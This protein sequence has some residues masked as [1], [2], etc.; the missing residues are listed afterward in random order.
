MALYRLPDHCTPTPIYLKQLSSAFHSCIPTSL[1]FL[2]TSL[3]VLSIISWLFAQVPQIIKNY[4]IHSA[5]G[6]SI[7]FLAEWL[8]GDLTNLLGALLTGQAA[9]QVVVAFYYVTVDLVLCYQYLWYAHVKEWRKKRALG[10]HSD[11]GEEDDDAS[12]VL[13]GVAPSN[14]RSSTESSTASDSK[15]TVKTVKIPA[16]KPMT[17]SH[18]DLDSSPLQEKDT[19]TN[20]STIVRSTQSPFPAASPKATL[21]ISVLCVALSRASPLNA[22]AQEST[23][24]ESISEFVGR[25]LSWM[26]TLLYLGSRLP[27]IYKNAVR[28]S[29]SGL[30]PTLFI[31]AFCGNFFY[32]ASLLTNPLAWD[33]Y[34]PYG[35]HGWVGSEG[36]DRKTWIALA[37][38]FWLGAAGVL[39]MDATI[40]V[41]FLVYGED[42]EKSMVLVEDREGKSRWL[43]VKGWMRGW[44]PSPNKDGHQDGSDTTALLDG[45]DRRSRDYGTA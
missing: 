41:Q 1:A 4:Q 11:G 16:K 36:S 21:L 45:E 37:A 9:W 17:R 43:A 34:P 40:G 26:S 15:D 23:A 20:K 10:Y 35:L 24:T 29:T 31:A 12:D 7:Y 8:L 2:S 30:S 25:V 32:S 28:R 5:S 14:G 13:V 3:G 19:P 27:Q 22:Q 6:L 38:P 18:E 42:V 33:S 39:M 44:V